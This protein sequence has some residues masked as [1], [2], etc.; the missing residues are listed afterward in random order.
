MYGPDPGGMRLAIEPLLIIGTSSSLIKR[1]FG[2]KSST[3]TVSSSGTETL[4]TELKRFMNLPLDI[5][6]LNV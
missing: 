6:C 2:A 5:A 4:A 1:L 3:S